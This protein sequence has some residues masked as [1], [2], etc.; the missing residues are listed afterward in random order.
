MSNY[1]DQLYEELGRV[2][3]FES[4]PECV[5]CDAKCNSPRRERWL[6]KEEARRMRKVLPQ[7][8]EVDGA[9]FFE[10]GRCPK[11]RDDGK[12]GIYDIRPLECRL[13]P[14]A[15]T[16]KNGRL[17]WMLNRACKLLRTDDAARIDFF[18]NKAHAYIDTIEP[19]FPKRVWAELKI[20]NDAICSFDPYTE[21]KDCLILRE[22]KMV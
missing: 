17:Y 12:C 16:E 9:L 2:N 10:K 19:F 6:L 5:D 8:V 11:L 15:F 1:L 14:V 7:I 13:N 18:K 3:I 22:V 4:M 21:G 20:I